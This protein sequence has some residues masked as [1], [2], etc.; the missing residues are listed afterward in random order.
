[1]QELRAVFN[2]FNLLLTAA[3]GAG[4]DTINIAYDVAGL[5]VY[6]DYIHMMCYDYHGTWD[7]RT[8]PNAP[9]KSS[10]VLNV[11]SIS[12]IHKLTNRALIT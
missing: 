9:L 11:V 4:E 6:L 8:G 7:G 3:F 10:D 2:K 5:S 12:C 1:M